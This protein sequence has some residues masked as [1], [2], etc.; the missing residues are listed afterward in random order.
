MARTIPVLIVA[1][2]V[3]LI[4]Y[5]A[6][7][8]DNPANQVRYDPIKNAEA[9]K[10]WAETDHREQVGNIAIKKWTWHKGGFDNVMI[11]TFTL[12]R[13]EGHYR[14]LRSLRT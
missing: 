11:A 3:G 1:A 5:G 10:N 14:P 13:R 7:R 8:S 4:G 2:I 6:T 9:K 12:L